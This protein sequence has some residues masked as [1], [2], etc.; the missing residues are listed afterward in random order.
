MN[1]F[2]CVTIIDGISDEFPDIGIVLASGFVE[3]QESDT[4]NLI[5]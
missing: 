3:D 2:Y 4:L 1:P 5:S